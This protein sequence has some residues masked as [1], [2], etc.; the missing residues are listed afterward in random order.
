MKNNMRRSA[1]GST[2]PESGGYSTR[3]EDDGE[4][5]FTYSASKVIDAYCIYKYAERIP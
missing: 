2:N 4:E 1:A 3:S 5:S